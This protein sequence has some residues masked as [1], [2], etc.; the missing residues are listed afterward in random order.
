MKAMDEMETKWLKRVL[1]LAEAE[2]ENL[3]RDDVIREHIRSE[4]RDAV[5]YLKTALAD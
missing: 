2:L 4:Q 5:A 1:E 3:E